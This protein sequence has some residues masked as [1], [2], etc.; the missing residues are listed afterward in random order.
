MA[1]K[2]YTPNR[3]LRSSGKL[4]SGWP[5]ARRGRPSVDHL[6]L[7]SKPITDGDVSMAD[8]CRSGSTSEGTGKG[9]PSAPQSRVRSDLGCHDPQR[10]CRGKVLSLRAAV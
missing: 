5:L 3:S 8:T 7:Q 9:E 6:V 10:G 1:G 4:K 2:R